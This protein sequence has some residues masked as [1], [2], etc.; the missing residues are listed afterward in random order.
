[1]LFFQDFWNF[2]GGSW[3]RTSNSIDTSSSLDRKLWLSSRL[4]WFVLWGKLILPHLIMF[5]FINLQPVISPRIIFTLNSFVFINIHLLFL[6]N[7]IFMC[8][9]MPNYVSTVGRALA[10]L[11]MADPG[12]IPGI[13]FDTSSIA[14]SN[15]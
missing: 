2:H 11:H 9:V 6:K 12:T 4:F 13:S 5:S 7:F 15:S 8:T 10:L 1:M 3:R 14:R